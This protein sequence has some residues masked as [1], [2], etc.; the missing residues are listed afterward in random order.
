VYNIIQIYKGGVLKRAVLKK[1]M[2]I[3]LETFRDISEHIPLPTNSIKVAV[4]GLSRAGKTV[5]ITS[6]IDQLLH[7]DKL[8]S[9]KSTR[10]PFK[11]TIKPPTKHSKRFDYYTLVD[12]LKNQHIW[13]EGTDE[14][15]HTILEVESKSRFSF[16][17]NSTFNIEL[18]DYPGEWLLDLTLLK[19]S[20]EEWSD[21]TIEWLRGVD[22]DL[23]RKYLQTIDSLEVDAQGGEIEQK[24]HQ[25]YKELI[26]YL[27]KN[28]YSQLTPGRFIMPSDLA[29]DPVLVF[30]PIP[31]RCLELSEVFK[32]RY[33]RYVEEVV[34]EIHLEHFKGFDR[35]VLLVDVVEALQNGYAC[36]SD[37]KAGLKS[38]LHLYDH[39]HKNFFSQWF[40][41]SIKKVVFVA[42]KADQVAASQH[43]NYSLLL[44]DMIDDLR[45]DMDISHIQTQT[46]IIASLKSTITIEKK[47]EGMMLSFIRGL[48]QED[49]EMHDLYP[50]E[51]PSKFPS[52]DEWSVDNYGYKSFLPPQRAYKESESL[53]HI[54]MD[55]LIEKLIG[56]LL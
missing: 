56:D 2:K 38:M 40:S 31:Q 51:M 36:Y 54:N 6:L 46:Q 49:G 24:L 48:L 33:D 34:K 4:T 5:F 39:K 10:Q 27:K 37:M 14:I 12:K 25:E 42:T 20:Y 28:H 11:V 43:A 23:A 18:I 26:I 53:E 35:Q 55:K 45:R 1:V 15:S 8:L 19:F 16:M 22:D 32:Q 47:Y 21:K 13:P 50:G 44:E 9:I 52:I 30:A 3:P 17:G 29:N 41:P 7:Q